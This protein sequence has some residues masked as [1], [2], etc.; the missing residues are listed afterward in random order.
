[1]QATTGA[2][3]SSFPAVTVAGDLALS[4]D[5]KT[6]HCDGTYF[7]DV[8][9]AAPG[10]LQYNTAYLFSRLSRNGE[11]LCSFDDK[12]HAVTILAAADMTQPGVSLKPPAGVTPTKLAAFSADDTT[13]FTFTHST[14]AADYIDLYNTLTGNHIRSLADR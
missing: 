1:M 7:F 10:L 13:L 9:G 11:A 6:L 14:T 3:L 8:S 2:V 4:P 12:A 5:L